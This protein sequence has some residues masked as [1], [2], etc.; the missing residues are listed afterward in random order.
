MPDA[1]NASV[2]VTLRDD[3][4]WSAIKS[5]GERTS[6]LLTGK[7]K[8]V[9]GVQIHVKTSLIR[10]Y[11]ERIHGER[12]GAEIAVECEHQTK[13]SRCT[14][15]CAYRNLIRARVLS[16]HNQS[17]TPRIVTSRRSWQYD[18]RRR[19]PPSCKQI[20]THGY[21][22]PYVPSSS[23]GDHHY[24]NPLSFE[25]I[26]FHKLISFVNVRCKYI[27]HAILGKVIQM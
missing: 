9:H 26:V 13:L 3:R 24:T 18:R 22:S 12:Q 16:L 17:Y 20:I 27:A 10:E 25:M 5:P 4:G 14:S 2:R 11:G 6:R 1:S 21:T 19:S 15:I 8:S 7:I 23:T